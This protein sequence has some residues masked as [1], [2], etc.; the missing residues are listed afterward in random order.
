MKRD[1]FRSA[2]SRD[3]EA[4]FNYKISRMNQQNYTRQFNFSF[5]IYYV[6]FGKL[7]EQSGTFPC[8]SKSLKPF[9]TLILPLST[10]RQVRI[11]LESPNAHKLSSSVLLIS[12][13]ERCRKLL[14]ISE[15]IY[16][17]C[18]IITHKIKDQLKENFLLIENFKRFEFPKVIW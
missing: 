16:Y 4:E 2:S 13:P 8:S 12:G 17:L 5:W 11:L 1:S 6:Y 10:F 15:I 14:V 3:D 9:I 18:M 7:P